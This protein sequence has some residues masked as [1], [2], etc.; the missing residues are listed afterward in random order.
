MMSA[1][2]FLSRLGELT[3]PDR[4]NYLLATV[5]GAVLV[6]VLLPFWLCWEIWSLLKRTSDLLRS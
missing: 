3:L 5:I 4:L 6:V 1:Q 2:M